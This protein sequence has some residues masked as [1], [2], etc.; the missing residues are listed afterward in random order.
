[1][2]QL[3]S[4]QVGGPASVCIYLILY[5]LYMTGTSVSAE[6]ECKGQRWILQ[7]LW[8]DFDTIFVC[9]LSRRFIGAAVRQKDLGMANGQVDDLQVRIFPYKSSV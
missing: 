8:F 2:K 6:E 9:I 3:F 5:Y 4:E 7:Y 1:M